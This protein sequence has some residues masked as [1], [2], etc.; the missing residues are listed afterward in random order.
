MYDLLKQHKWD[1]FINNLKSYKDFDVNIRDNHN[2]Y[3]ITYAIMFNVIDVIKILIEHG[4]RVDI[5]DKY[6]RTILYTPIMNGFIDVVTL[7]LDYKNIGKS[8]VSQLDKYDLIPLHYAIAEKS[9]DI[10]NILLSHGSDVGHKNLDGNDALMLSIMSENIDVFKTILPHVKNINLTNKYNETS[11]HIACKKNLDDIVALL[12]NNKINI[13]AQ[14]MHESTALHLC[15]GHNI[16]IVKVLMAGGAN[17][18]LQDANGN[19]P[20]HYAVLNGNNETFDELMGHSVNCNLWNGNVRIPLHIALIKKKYTF[21]KYLLPKSDVTIQDVDG[22]SCFHYIVQH[23]LWKSYIDILITKHLDITSLNKDNQ[24]VIDYVSK[25]DIEQ[26]INLVVD[27]YYDKL[28]NQHGTWSKEFDIICSKTSLSPDELRKLGTHDNSQVEEKCKSLIRDYITEIVHDNTFEK[29]YP[30]KKTNVCIKLENNNVKMCTFSGTFIDIIIE[31]IFLLKKHD[32]V[33]STITPNLTNQAKIKK[34]YKSAGYSVDDQEIF[35]AEIIWIPPNIYFSDDFDKQFK[36]CTSTK[37]F[38]IIP[39]GITI[40]SDSHANYLIYDKD[41]NEIERFEPHGS[42]IPTGFDYNHTLLDETLKKH[43]KNITYIKPIDYLPK[44]SFQQ[45]DVRETDEEHIG[46]PMGFCAVWTVWY[47]D[48][49]LTYNTLTRDKL[50]DLLIKTIKSQN[51]SFKNLIRNYGVHITKLR[52]D[53]L[54]MS[55]MNINDW[56]N[57]KYNDKQ[58]ATL[59]SNIQKEIM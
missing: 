14:D 7:L 47:V 17:V 9:L 43:F 56:I 53:L 11:L 32:N 45:M 59:Y 38:T 20:L 54:S 35:N 40:K 33:C 19:T 26:F 51:I 24:R 34:F 50:V 37:R 27:S 49:R 12:I 22:N 2:N 44:V 25:G 5:L 42:T 48:M 52:D 41:T 16:N 23:N 21:V 3:Y 8:L 31:L 58:I 10:V 15:A 6:G 36:I 46:D 55:N 13:D 4:A 30:T 29:S 57:G 18:N 28:R 1:T 39:L